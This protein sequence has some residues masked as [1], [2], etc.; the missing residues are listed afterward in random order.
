MFDDSDR[1]RNM[2]GM[3]TEVPSGYWRDETG[4]CR[5]IEEKP[6][7]LAGIA[8]TGLVWRNGA[9]PYWNSLVNKLEACLPEWRTA[10]AGFEAIRQ[11]MSYLENR[12]TSGP[13]MGETVTFGNVRVRCRRSYEDIVSTPW[14]TGPFYLVSL[15]L[16]SAP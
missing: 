12:W 4:A 8:S 2:P 13:C 5:P 6:C 16:W 15:T 10:P 1:C 7:L 9:D 11:A 3:Q 14:Q